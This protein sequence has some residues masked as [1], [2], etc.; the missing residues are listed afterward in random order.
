MIAAASKSRAG[1]FRRDL[2]PD[3][4]TYF[5]SQGRVTGKGKQRTTGCQIH[6]GSD[7]LGFNAETGCWLCRNCG[8]KGG[9]VLAYHMQ[10]HELG[11][12]EAA[13]QLGAWINNS[14][15]HAAAITP[16]KA[17][18]R[19]AE[20]L[21]PQGWS[22]YARE[23]WGASQLLRGTIGEQCLLARGCALPPADSDLRFHP[24]LRHF[25]SGYSGPA[26]LGVVTDAVT[27][28]PMGVHRTWI[29]A[30]GKADVTPARMNLGAKQGGVIRLWPDE[31]VTRGLAIAEGIE[32]AL[33]VAHDYKPVWCVIDAGNMAALPVLPGIETLVI[34]ADHDPAGL[35]AAHACA[36]RWGAAGVDVRVIVPEAEHS[37]W[38]DARAAA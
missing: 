22:D 3:A 34:G 29:T 24:D 30:S 32:T 6:G 17:P 20:A 9:D 26:L 13:R 28:E 21:Q 35:N 7:S 10:A 31:C 18:A 12:I 5:E 15:Q 37:D 1:E 36:E 25:P 27:R 11:F 16:S 19:P 38:N 2:L 33:S 14:G 4:V 8:A 23:M